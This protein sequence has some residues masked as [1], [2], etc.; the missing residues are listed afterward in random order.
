MAR[1]EHL[2]ARRPLLLNAVKLRQNPNDCAEWIERANL[3][4]QSSQFRQAGAALEEA[5]QTVQ[6]TAAHGSSSSSS[7]AAPLSQVVTRLVQIYQDHYSPNGVTAARDLLDRVCRQ[8]S[9]AHGFRDA[10]ELADAWAAWIELELKHEAW[11]EALALARQ[12][13]ARNVP[14]HG[15]GK[16]LLTRSLRL[17]DLFLDLEESLG[18]VQTTKDAYNRALE[19]K[20]ATVQHVLNFGAFLTEQKYFEESC[21]AY[22]R[23]LELFDFPHAGSKLL[24]TAYLEAFL[25]RYQGT[26]VERARNLFQR[27][28]QN[29]PPDD[30]VPFFMMNGEFEEQYGLTK[31]A[32]SV[33]RAMCEKIPMDEKYAAYQVYIAKTVKYL[34]LPATREIYQEAIETLSKDPASAVKMCRD[35]AKME[36]GLQQVERARAIYAY[37]AQSADPRRTPEYWKEWNDFEISHGNEETFR[38]ML[39]IKRSMEAAFSTVNYNAAGMD[40]RVETM[41]NE[42][43]MKMVASAEGIELDETNTNNNTNRSNVSG[44]VPSKRSAVAANLHDMEERVAKL[45]KATGGTTTVTLG[46]ADNDADDDEIDLDDIDA[47]IE[48]AATEGGKAKAVPARIVSI[49]T[50]AVPDALFGTLAVKD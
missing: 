10:Q 21:T 14:R 19:T 2:T 9:T 7:S 50:K 34:G 39:R 13:V 36:M 44:F 12:A 29:C 3:Y 1:A 16:F 30:C 48:E 41:S 5:L 28:L 27:C 23:G 11:D 22:E 8:R 6:N 45:R 32:L 49:S 47:E 37:G 46:D 43:A 40:E 20:V 42:E 18:T 25:K 15:G 35:F 17:W 38:E 24:W 33:Y 26:K 31:R 4:C